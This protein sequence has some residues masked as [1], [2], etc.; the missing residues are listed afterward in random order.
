[1]LAQY[2]T[3][4]AAQYAAALFPAHK[5]DD[6]AP[7]GDDDEERKQLMNELLDRL[8]SNEVDWSDLPPKVQEIIGPLAESAAKDGL[9]QLDVHT[10]AAFDLVNEAAV[11][12]ARERSAE[13]VGMKYNADG[14][15][16]DNPRAEWSISDSTRDML[17]DTITQATEEGWSMDRLAGAISA[18]DAFSDTRAMM[19][20]RT[21]SATADVQGNLVG[22]KAAAEVGV[23][24][25]KEWITAGDELVSEDC[26]A[27]AEQGPIDLDDTFQSGA[28]AP[29]EHP[30]CRCD[31][32]PVRL[33]RED[34]S[35]DDSADT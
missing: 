18:D 34:D 23:Q 4:K 14:E 25:Q 11:E 5:A 24:V 31:L 15:L 22:Y 21:E 33:A 17:R 19:I 10:G 6:G 16:A 35:S 20:A 7:I 32:V 27:N 29:P 26:A 30:N 1:M 3:A 13:L 2:L 9:T 28:S 8:D 12:W